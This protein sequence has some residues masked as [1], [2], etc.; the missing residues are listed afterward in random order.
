S[1]KKVTRGVDGCPIYSA[2]SDLGGT[3]GAYDRARSSTAKFRLAWRTMPISDNE[4]F[5]PDS[6]T[7][8]L[9]QEAGLPR[10]LRPGRATYRAP[11]STLCRSHRLTHC[12]GSGRE[13]RDWSRNLALVQNGT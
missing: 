5:P 13:T 4:E 2:K 12:H 6:G 1:T 8:R 10:I 3:T 7:Q 11:C 9:F